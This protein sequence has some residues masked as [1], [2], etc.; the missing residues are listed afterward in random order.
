M[1]NIKIICFD[2]DNVICKTV[3]KNYKNSKP[4]LK[5]IKL[6]NELYDDGYKLIVFTARGM[7]KF[8]GNLNLVLKAYKKMT[9]SQLKKWK[10]N[11]HNLY[12]GKPSYDIFVD[13]KA[14]GFKK[15]WQKNFKKIL[16]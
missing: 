12:F 7:G 6:I 14:F 13:D 11:Y 2:L 9:I 10:I 8:N 1:K 4:I 15:D 3:G 16:K 5:L